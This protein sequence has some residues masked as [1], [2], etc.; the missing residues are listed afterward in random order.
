MSCSPIKIGLY[1][2][3]G[4]PISNEWVRILAQKKWEAQTRRGL[5]AVKVAP[6]NK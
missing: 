3:I 2:A 1:E 5:T 6:R 4:V